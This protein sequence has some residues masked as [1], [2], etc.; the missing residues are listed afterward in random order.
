ML[1]KEKAAIIYM[2]MRELLQ[3]K[4]PC[5]YNAA[6]YPCKIMRQQVHAIR[7]YQHVRTPM[8]MSGEIREYA[9]KN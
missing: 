3:V 5:L 8:I 6:W 1:Q 2:L 7:S 4:I 9:R